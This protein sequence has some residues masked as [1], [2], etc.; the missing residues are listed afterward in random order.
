MQLTQADSTGTDE[1]IKVQDIDFDPRAGRLIAVTGGS[2]RNGVKGAVLEFSSGMG[3]SR[4]VVGSNGIGR[5]G[6][7]D[8]FSRSAAQLS[9]RASGV[10][11]THRM[12]QVDRRGCLLPPR[13]FELFHAGFRGQCR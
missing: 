13:R 3:K 9:D 10:I 12:Q 5:L 8:T 4:G 2:D 6:I 7:S 1:F 11:V